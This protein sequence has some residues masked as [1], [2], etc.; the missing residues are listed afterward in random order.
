MK[1]VANRYI[2][3]DE[4]KE[5]KSLLDGFS[6]SGN[7]TSQMQVAKGKVIRSS[8]SI[9]W[10]KEGDEILYTKPRSFKIILE[11]GPHT[12]ITDG[13]VVVVL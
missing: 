11:D 9:D 13:N 4:I 3:L 2:I 12:A 1:K 7:D 10:L 8:D 6:L 5:E